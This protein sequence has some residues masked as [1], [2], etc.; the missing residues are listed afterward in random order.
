M[1]KVELLFPCRYQSLKPIQF[2]FRD[3]WSVA[4]LNSKC[5]ERPCFAEVDK[6]KAQI[7][8]APQEKPRRKAQLGL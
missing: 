8:K 3:G 2:K 5:C 1:K 6:L 4:L 7:G